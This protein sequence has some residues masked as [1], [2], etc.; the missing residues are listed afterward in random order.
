MVEVASSNTSGRGLHR[1]GVLLAAVVGLLVGLLFAVSPAGA[2]GISD[3]ADG[4]A[5]G[6][7]LGLTAQ[8]AAEG[9][10]AADGNTTGLAPQSAAD[11]DAVAY[12]NAQNTGVVSQVS[13][14]TNHTCAVTDAG[15]AYC[16]GYNGQGQLGDGTDTSWLTEPTKVADND[17]FVNG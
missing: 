9:T 15:Y 13:A 2:A 7:P 10:A 14:G 12:I 4:A 1:T 3:A 8:G 17:G 5:D 6:S 11:A 16:W